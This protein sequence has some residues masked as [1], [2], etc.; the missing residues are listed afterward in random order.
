MRFLS[1]F[2][3]LYKVPHGN[4][5]RYWNGNMKRIQAH[6]EVSIYFWD[7]RFLVLLSD[8]LKMQ[9]CWEV[10]GLKKMAGKEK[11]MKMSIGSILNG[12]KD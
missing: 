7:S 10:M 4:Q 12:S 9:V 1:F 2:L 3:L 5:V 6:C 11:R 8:N